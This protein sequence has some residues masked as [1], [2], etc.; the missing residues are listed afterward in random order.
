MT[1]SRYIALVDLDAFYASVEVLEDETLRGK[2]LLIGGSPQSRG[3]VATASYEARNFGCRSA[4]PVAQA[5]KLCPDAILIEPKFELYKRYSNQ[6]MQILKQESDIFQQMSIDEAYLDLSKKCTSQKNAIEAAFHIKARIHID[7]GLP[8]S[9]GLASNKVVAKIACE[10]AK[11][12]GFNVIPTGEESMFLSELDIRDLPGIGPKTTKRLNSVGFRKISDIANATPKKLTQLIG[13]SGAVLHKYANGN[14]DSPVSSERI[15]KSIS[16]E[17][18]FNSDITYNDG[19]EI[20][21]LVVRLTNQVWESVNRKK[22]F[23]RTVSVK[24]RYSDFRTISRSKTVDSEITSNKAISDIAS[25]LT[26]QTLY[27]SDRLR[28]IGLTVS[29]FYT[30]AR[31]SQLSFDNFLN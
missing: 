28:L 23:P 2:P 21:T 31:S 12:N 8:C 30:H 22:L 3:V 11:P 1:S 29:N 20:D 16:A 27:P 9:V 6:V 25:E 5:L 26:K 24:L 15:T 7:I 13:S 17:R 4:M 10:Y 18:T 14:D 19:K